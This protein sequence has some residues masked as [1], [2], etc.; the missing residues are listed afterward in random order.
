[1]LLR[2]FDEIEKH[3]TEF[4]GDLWLPPEHLWVSVFA[5]LYMG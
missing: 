2:I 4:P 5:Y 3:N 1:M